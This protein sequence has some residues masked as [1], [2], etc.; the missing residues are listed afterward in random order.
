MYLRR[1][2]GPADL[3]KASFGKLEGGRNPSLTLVKPGAD[4]I[5]KF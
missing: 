1:V 4:V 2:E 3:Y 5:N